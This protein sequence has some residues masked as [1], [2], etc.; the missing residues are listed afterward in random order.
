MLMMHT[1]ITI[2]KIIIFKFSG[3]LNLI[4]TSKKTKI[5]KI[6]M[7]TS[8]DLARRA[9]KSKLYINEE[10]ISIGF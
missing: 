9:K 4:S 7:A 10:F 2:N 8:K 5:D 6:M 3:L 1:N